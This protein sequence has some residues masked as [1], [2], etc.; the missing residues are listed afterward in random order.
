M[1]S[2]VGHS[3]GPFEQDAEHAT[4]NEEGERYDE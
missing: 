4:N 2:S 3:S 1:N